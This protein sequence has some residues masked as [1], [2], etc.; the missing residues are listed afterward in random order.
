MWRP[1]VSGTSALMGSKAHSGSQTHLSHRGENPTAHVTSNTHKLLGYL[2][3]K[4]VNEFLGVLYGDSD[5]R[6]YNR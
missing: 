6:K 1:S 3:A 2:R 5:C 4:H